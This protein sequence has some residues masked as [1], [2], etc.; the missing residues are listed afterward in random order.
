MATTVELEQEWEPSYGSWGELKDAVEAGGGVLRV[1]MWD[2]RYLEE[3]GRLGVHVRASI[4]RKLMGL[5]LAHLPKDLPAYQEQA[6]VIYKL[7]TPAAAVIDAVSGGGTREAEAALRR[8]NTSRDSEKLL[9]VTEK[10]AELS[11]ILES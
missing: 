8:L 9:A 4:S 7:G 3:A 5:G 11:E 10:F 2:L 6:V 1:M